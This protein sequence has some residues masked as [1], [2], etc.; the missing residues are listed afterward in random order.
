MNSDG[1]LRIGQI[2]KAEPES[3]QQLGKVSSASAFPILNSTGK[4]KVGRA[5]YNQPPTPRA[6]AAL[7]AHR[8]TIFKLLC[9]RLE[10]PFDHLRYLE[11]TR[12]LSEKLSPEKR[13]T[14]FS[15]TKIAE[16][17]KGKGKPTMWQ[18]EAIELATAKDGA[19]GLT[20]EWDLPLS[21]SA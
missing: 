14:S 21:E 2:L 10:I 3:P 12:R 16:W 4:T 17:E 7:R 18:E 19:P 5:N 8:K 1:T 6:S 13:A 11:L 9:N 20:F 15:A